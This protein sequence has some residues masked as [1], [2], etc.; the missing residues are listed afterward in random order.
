M[1]DVARHSENEAWHVIYRALYGDRG[2]WI[3]PLEMFEENVFVD[4]Q[5]RKRFEYIGEIS[6]HV[7]RS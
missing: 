1:I 6:C 3:R 5:E 7:V 2:L 4:N